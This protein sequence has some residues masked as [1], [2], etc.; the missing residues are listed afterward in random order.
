MKQ[1]KPLMEKVLLSLNK[2]GEVVSA[3]VGGRAVSWE[4]EIIGGQEEPTQQKANGTA[5]K[6]KSVRSVCVPEGLHCRAHPLGDF[7]LTQGY[8]HMAR[9]ELVP[10]I[11]NGFLCG[12]RMYDGISIVEIEPVVNETG[13]VLSPA[14]FETEES[15]ART[16]ALRQSLSEAKGRSPGLIMNEVDGLLDTMRESRYVA[17][18]DA[19]RDRDPVLRPFHRVNA[20]KWI[21]ALCAPDFAGIFTSDW[22][23]VAPAVS[24]ALGHDKSLKYYA[25]VRS[26]LPIETCDQLCVAAQVSDRT[27][28]SWVDGD[29]GLELQK[30][31]DLATAARE[32]VLDVVISAYG[33]RRKQVRKD[34]IHTFTDYIRPITTPDKGKAVGVY[35]GSGCSEDPGGVIL[36]RPGA[37]PHVLYWLH[38]PARAPTNIG[39]DG[40][41]MPNVLHGV[42]VFP[43][44]QSDEKPTLAMQRV[45]NTLIQHGYDPKKFGYAR[46]HSVESTLVSRGGSLK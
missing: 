42:P 16:E 30:A 26:A 17:G 32:R 39:G 22:N 12:L 35:A 5:K 40:W 9:P 23:T 3:H 10:S 15:L 31:K 13:T 37:G 38:G 44:A 21:P 24:A 19:V 25:A 29:D 2:E 43:A 36:Q 46:L 41:S 14:Y 28:Q 33:L 4:W 34:A 45:M 8:V 7:M 18:S 20:D 1:V 6:S 11:D 27:W